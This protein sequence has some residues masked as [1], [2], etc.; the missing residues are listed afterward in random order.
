M[1]YN[2]LFN[3]EKV[4]DYLRCVNKIQ[5]V[6]KK[7]GCE[8]RLVIANLS[9]RNQ[10]GIRALYS[11][12]EKEKR[13]FS[14]Q[15]FQI[16]PYEYYKNGNSVEM[17]KPINDYDIHKDFLNMEHTLKFY[18]KNVKNRFVTSWKHN[19]HQ[20]NLMNDSCYKGA[21]IIKNFINCF[22]LVDSLSVETSLDAMY[23]YNYRKGTLFG[24]DGLVSYHGIKK[25]AYYAYLFMGMV[26]NFYLNHNENMMVFKNSD[27]NYHI[28]AH[29]CKTLGYKY[30]MEE[31]NLDIHHIDEYYEN[32]ESI[33]IQA[34]INNVE[35]GTYTVKAKSISSQGGSVQD[36]LRRMTN[37]YYEPLHPSD[38][39]FLK[40]V[41]IP[42]IT[43]KSI[44]VKDGVLF[45]D[46][47]LRANEF[48]MIHIIK[49]F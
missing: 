33:K 32:Q 26:G 41:S 6:L 16:E 18:K 4:H 20:F 21:L 10:E 40:N 38:I 43:I 15:S 1:S 12:L 37:N 24:G 29:N 47:V 49:Q 25:P 2:T 17:V 42:R 45:I 34:T 22:G 8:N 3:E 44:E 27:G 39:E 23:S 14:N 36:E 19:L 5:E 7:Y 13:T 46:E 11:Y 9:L 35:N 31:D 48:V 30:Y 28:I